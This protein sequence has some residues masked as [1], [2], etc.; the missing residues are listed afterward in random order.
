MNPR[1]ALDIAPRPEFAAE[2]EREL[3][4]RL[5]LT[6][7][8][9]GRDDTVAA[10]RTPAAGGTAAGATAASRPARW[11]ARTLGAAAVIGA[12]LTVAMIVDRRDSTSP[13]RPPSIDDTVAPATTASP[14]TT[15]AT[16]APTTSASVAPTTDAVTTSVESPTPIA[17]PPHPPFGEMPAGTYAIDNF[18][19][20][21]VITT[22]NTWIRAANV[23]KAF[24]LGRGLVVGFAVTWGVI[25]G[26]DPL[27]ALGSLC[28]GAIEFDAPVITELLGAEAIQLDGHFTDTCVITITT[29]PL[30]ARIGEPGSTIR[31][32]AAMVDDTVVVVLAGSSDDA[33]PA[34]APEIDALVASMELRAD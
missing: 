16:T 26:D 31:L 30:I 32:I 11:A 7:S 29:D 3:L 2:L 33:W 9:N 27:S 13:E 25:P 6:V 19:L 14:P 15:S 20:P 8:A 24:T 12:V 17:R 34:L 10:A 5:S 21:F 1:D 28:P 18:V 22:S 23:Q 4:R